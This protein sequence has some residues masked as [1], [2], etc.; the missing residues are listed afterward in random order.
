[1]TSGGLFL[2]LGIAVTNVKVD[3]AIFF[4]FSLNLGIAEDG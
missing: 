1:M 2:F 3:G 4:E